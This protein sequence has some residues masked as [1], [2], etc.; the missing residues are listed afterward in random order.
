MSN[1]DYKLIKRL[2][3]RGKQFLAEGNK[4]AA[5]KI[6]SVIAILKASSESAVEEEVSV[7][8]VDAKTVPK[9][10]IR[11]RREKLNQLRKKGSEKIRKLDILMDRD[12]KGLEE[13]KKVRKIVKDIEHNPN[14]YQREDVDEYVKELDLDNY[15]L[16]DEAN[17]I[18]DDI[19]EIFKKKGKLENIPPENSITVDTGIPKEKTLKKPSP[20][21]RKK[22]KPKNK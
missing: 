1:K 10:L 9:S 7:E 11:K 19:F 4:E 15:E 8:D 5:R 16:T 2:R 18:L 12:N 3:A 22:P 21:R 17:Q 6:K 14:M 13:K 20:P